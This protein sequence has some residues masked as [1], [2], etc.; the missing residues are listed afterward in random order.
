[1]GSLLIL[2]VDDFE[3]NAN[4]SV[5]M[6]YGLTATEMSILKFLFLTN[7][8]NITC[9]TLGN[10]LLLLNIIIIIIIVVVVLFVSYVIVTVIHIVIVL[11]HAAVSS[12]RC[13]TACG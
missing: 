3:G 4:I 11:C 7:G 12:P 13:V 10:L 2:F 1:M 5:A 6:K 8:I 9:F